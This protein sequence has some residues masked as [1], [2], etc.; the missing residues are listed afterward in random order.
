MLGELL[1]N[2]ILKVTSY[3]RGLKK[4]LVLLISLL[5]F[6]IYIYIWFDVIKEVFFLKKKKLLSSLSTK[7]TF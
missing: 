2:P 1:T 7:L 3:L 5:I 4:N 6:Y